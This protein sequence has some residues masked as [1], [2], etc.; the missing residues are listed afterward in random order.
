MKIP[1]NV[2]VTI[3]DTERGHVLINAYCEL[4]SKLYCEPEE[5]MSVRSIFEPESNVNP[6]PKRKKTPLPKTVNIKTIFTKILM[7]QLQLFI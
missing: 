6:Q 5:D 4:V 1:C 7:Q 2:K 3:A